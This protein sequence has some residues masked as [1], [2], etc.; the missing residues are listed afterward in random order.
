MNTPP[1][2]PRSMM[3]RL[4]LVLFAALAI[5]Y[6]GTAFLNRIENRQLAS[7]QRIERFAKQLIVADQ[8]AAHVEPARRPRLMADMRSSGLALN[9]VPS[10]VITDSSTG[11][12]HLGRLRVR[13]HEIEPSLAK[14]DLRLS[15]L[16]SDDGKQRDL[17]GALRLDDG[18]F[19]TFRVRPFLAATPSYA[20]TA[21]MHLALMLLVLGAAL[22]MTWT[23]V[24]PLEE[25]ARAAD[26]TGR[27]EHAMIPVSGPW[28]VQRV[29]TA[30]RAMQSRLLQMMSDHTNAFVAL[31]HDLRTPIQRMQ[32]RS[33]LIRDEEL[34]RGMAVDLADMEKF[35]SSVLDFIES[36]LEEEDKLIDLAALA[37]TVAD[38]ISDAGFDVEYDGPD[39]LQI[40]TKPIAIKRALANLVDNACRHGEQVRIV[41]RADQEVVLS[42]EDDGPGIEPGLHELAFQ[43]LQR[44]LAKGPDY[45]GGSGFGLA[46][47][48]NAVRAMGATISLD[49]SSM[50]GLAA[51]IT[52]PRKS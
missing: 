23:L 48:K 46:I 51:K 44:N 19:V 6:A 29:A 20:A 3:A 9:W 24:R 31:S 33:G 7:H 13:L 18:S 15:L 41:L 16:P 25:L 35:V 40:W 49:Q 22:F 26:A 4:A 42:V 47:V 8:I 2:L 11:H 37:M 43:P 45:A 21:V 5:E 50:G 1:W 12:A 32:L 38:N 36:G 39:T 30:F 34:R 28:E 17:L 14:R 27:R 52:L 10:T